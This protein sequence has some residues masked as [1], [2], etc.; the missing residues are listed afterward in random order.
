MTRG[1]KIAFIV[2]GAVIV[3]SLAGLVVVAVL[4]R[5]QS[6]RL[7][8]IPR[9]HQEQNEENLPTITLT[10]DQAKQAVDAYL[11][12]YNNPDLVLKEIMIFQ[13]NAYARVIEQS[14]GIGAMELLVD[15]NSL[16]VMPEYGAD[17]MWNLKYGMM[18]G[19]RGGMMNPG[20]SLSGTPQALTS[21]FSMPVTAD[22]AVKLAQQYL[23]AAQP[24]TTAD[25]NPDEFYGYYT[26]D[27]LKNDA[28][29]GMLS[30][31]GYTGQIIYHDWHG[32]FI[33]QQEW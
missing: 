7:A 1:F 32:A 21:P 26:V 23:D 24:G 19:G 18:A 13:R 15:P 25:P 11:A 6:G 4:G 20:Y 8:Q 3:L 28:P 29:V 31:N 14:T 9:L 30:V 22:Q 10:I 12:Q 5:V 33:T 2:V 17:M 16:Q 27:I